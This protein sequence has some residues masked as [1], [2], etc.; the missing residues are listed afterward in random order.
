VSTVLL[1]ATSPTQLE[2]NLGA[3][4]VA[5]RLTVEHMAAMEAILDNAPERYSGYGKPFWARAVD[6]L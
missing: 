5:Q 2:E 6:V 1:G 4:A 3:L